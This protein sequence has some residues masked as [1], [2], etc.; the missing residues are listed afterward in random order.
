MTRQRKILYWTVGVCAA[1]LALLVTA[2]L[3]LPRLV[4]TELVRSKIEST[5]SQ[6]LGGTLTYDRVALSIL[7]RPR[8]ILRR[9]KVEIPG[10][11][12]AALASLDIYPALLPLLHGDLQITEVHLE[13]PGVT[14]VLPEVPGPV[15]KLKG[16]A[17]GPGNSPEQV[18]AVA[19]KKMPGIIIV[20]DEGRLTVMRGDQTIL[21]IRDLNG[22]VAFLPEEKGID[23]RDDPLQDSFRVEGNAKCSIDSPGM[24]MGPV[25]LFV[26]QFEALPRTFT[27]S[28]ISARMAD[29]SV[30]LSGK[31][32]N[33]RTT[34][35]KANLS[36]SGTAGPNVLQWLRDSASL[37]P[38]LTLR[39]PLALSDTRIRWEQDGTLQIVGNASIKNGPSLAF[40]VQ[41]SPQSITL[42]RLAV[43]DRE[44]Q[45]V[46]TLQLSERIVDLSFSGN[47][48]PKTMDD[49]FGHE[50]FPFGWI[51][52][53]LKVHLP[54][55]DLT[56]ASAEGVIETEQMVVPWKSKVPF[57]IDR[58][59]LSALGRELKLDPASITL[60]RSRG[61]FSGTITARDIGVVLDLDLASP[62]VAWDD[63]RELF[64]PKEN[65]EGTEKEPEEEQDKPK[66]RAIP[67]RGTLRVNV[68]ALRG[69]RYTIQPVR[70][71]I[72]LDQDRTRYDIREAAVCGIGITGTAVVSRGASDLSLNVSAKEQEL[73]PTLLCLAGSDLEVTGKFDL[74]GSIAGAGPNEELPRSLGGKIAFAAKNGRVYNDVLVVPIL[75]HKKTAD[76][77]GDR[78]ADAKK[79]GIP[80]D[81]FGIRGT[82]NSGKL[83]VTDGVIKSPL[84]NLAANGVVDL[85]NERLDITILMAP[86]KTVDAVVKKVPLLGNILGGT[87]VTVPL[88]VHGPFKDPKVTPLPPSAIGDG[89]MGIMKRTL[90]LPFEV[91]DD[92][93]PRKR[94]AETPLAQ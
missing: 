4:N 39:S 86:F 45:A 75:K 68:D 1:L 79:N 63:L 2:V 64:L 47:L 12:S 23:L 28:R 85:V 65:A 25:S 61:V 18:L 70:G 51:K 74:T 9:L 17:S 82:I 53:D 14:I 36:V 62:E 73:A 56:A 90:E 94:S 48:T 41:R 84:M 27:F 72:T 29:L 42:K 35:R 71:T 15:R 24:P 31:I 52:G 87:L 46:I 76:L 78:T 49:L 30:S 22:R 81:T 54:L 11:T 60:G 55:D 59:V 88:R 8:I 37:S 33:Y 21:T 13:R 32:D 3:L 19:T 66:K 20:I 44:S 26:E 57:F 91:V 6:D 83:K 38:L 40:D 69:K 50:P 77:L 10:K 80:Y 5:I 7:P 67:I 89:L 43:R 93:S 16:S 34:H 92:V 58:L